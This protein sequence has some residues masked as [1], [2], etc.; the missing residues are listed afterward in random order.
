MEERA[1]LLPVFVYG[2]LK[3]GCPLHAA[4]SGCQFSGTYRTANR[5]PMLI[6]GPRYAPMMLDQPGVG[7]RIIGE[8]YVVDSLALSKIDGLESIGT[9]GNLRISIDIE[10]FAG[11]A[12]RKA[13]AYLK[14]P[15]LAEPAHSDYLAYYQDDGR[16]IAPSRARR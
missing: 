6:A 2:T 8:L 4:I 1:S 7:H 3:R 5:Y 15:D 12:K 11:G 9:P 14:G 10:P 16:F 13:W